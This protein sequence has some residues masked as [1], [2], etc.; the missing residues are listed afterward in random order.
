MGKCPKD[1]ATTKNFVWNESSSHSQEKLEKPVGGGMPPS[2]YRRVKP[3][4]DMVPG[5]TL[6]NLSVS[7][8]ENC[9][10]MI[11]RLSGTAISG[12]VQDELDSVKF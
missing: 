2:H 6:L 8:A 9:E 4:T 12:S 3:M 5:N 1:E 11:H 7:T 10:F